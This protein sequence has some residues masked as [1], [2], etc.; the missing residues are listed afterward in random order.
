[1]AQVIRALNSTGIEQFRGCLARLRG[2]MAVDPPLALLQDRNFT[3]ELPVEIPIDAQPVAN[4]LEL[5]R[6]LCELLGPLPPDEMDRNAGL[7]AW[8]SLFLFDQVCPVLRDGGRRPGQDYRHIPDFSYRYRHRHLLHGPYQVYRRHGPLSILLLS[9]PLNSESALYHE[10]ASRQDLVANRGVIE[11]TLSLYMDRKRG[12]PKH[13][14]QATKGPPG[15]I[16]RFVRVLQQLD[17][18]YDIY[19]MSGKD[20]IDL[21]P[22]E[23]D[24]WAN[25]G[26]TAL[27]L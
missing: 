3:S 13:G 8:M 11:A 19:G 9:G 2:G 20:M 16:R 22:G 15:S 24:A 6:F 5:G 25:R 1:M 21:L 17:V 26:Q 23:F 4:R 18:N 10:I 12:A 27:P 14:C 7:W